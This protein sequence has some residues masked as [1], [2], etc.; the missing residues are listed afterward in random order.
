MKTIICNLKYFIAIFT[1]LFLALLFTIK[2]SEAS[3]MKNNTSQKTPICALPKTDAELK[4]ILTPEQYKIMRENGTEMPFK[5]PYWH[6]TKPGIYVDV[7]TGEPLFSSTEK[8]DSKTGWPSFTSPINK[9]QIIEKSD[10][11]MGMTRTEVRSK[12]SNS[13]LGHLF[14]DGP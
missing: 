14:N 5:N 6:N 9:D 13:H 4:K 7:I 2:S 1:I 12:N 10:T 11:S 3:T 8:F